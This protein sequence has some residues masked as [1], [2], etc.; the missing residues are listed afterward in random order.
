LAR[1]RAF[2]VVRQ[3]LQSLV[4]KALCHLPANV[5]EEKLMKK[6][7]LLLI[8]IAIC[9][10]MSLHQKNAALLNSARVGDT[11]NVKR[12]IDRGA[13][14][15]FRDQYG[16]TPLHLAI[17]NKHPDTAKVLITSGANVN[18]KGALEDTPLHIS[19]YQNE[20]ELATLLRQKGANDTLLNRYGL[21]P[22]EME[23]LPEIEAKIVN[24][25]A[26]LN[27]NGNW[28]D[29]AKARPLFDELK[30][31]QDKYLINSLVLQII[32]TSNLRLQVLL[33]SV[34]LGIR[35]SEE[36]LVGIL[37]VYGDKSMAEDFLNSGSSTLSDGGRQWANTHGYRISTGQGS[38]RAT[39]G[40]F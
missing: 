21:N 2:N 7:V 26:M 31:R 13:D 10:C 38:H 29:R 30:A 14:I 20:R 16:D 25:S 19:I 28:S 1:V 34:K 39:W 24:L 17:K 23:A 37:M 35:G 22:S 33:V 15:N 6:Y 8:S 32:K 5:K 4:A 40:S 11:S 27:P 9:G 18:E 36:K 12:M 3:S